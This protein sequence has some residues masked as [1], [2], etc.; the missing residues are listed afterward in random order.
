MEVNRPD[1]D[2]GHTPPARRRQADRSA[3]TRAALLTAAR[4]LFAEKGFAATG[5]EE[6]VDAAGV[7]RGAM[8][9]HFAN[10]EDLFRAVYIELE[11]EIVSDVTSAAAEGGDAMDRLRR[12]AHAFLDAALDRAVQRVV[13]I[14]APSV[15]GWEE[16]QAISE[17]YG[18]GLV[19]EGLQAVMDAGAVD[20]QPVEPLAHVLLAALHEAALYVAQSP[21]PERA[22]SEVGDIVDRLLDRL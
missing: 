13:L 12:G 19:R 3:A 5:R 1:G 20:A 2:I 15:L 7:T 11:T 16:R 21:L 9:H 10:K 17:S 4:R 14:D 6:I 18:L 8:Y 22:R